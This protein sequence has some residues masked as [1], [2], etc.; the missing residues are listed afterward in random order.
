MVNFNV[1]LEKTNQSIIFGKLKVILNKQEKFRNN[2]ARLVA[3][4][5]IES[6][7]REA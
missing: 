4:L 3:V 7:L 2:R 1:G 5:T 6:H